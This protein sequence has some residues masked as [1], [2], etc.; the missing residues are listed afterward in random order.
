[1]IYIDKIKQIKRYKTI[2]LAV[3]KHPHVIDFVAQMF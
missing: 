1:M 3:E 2:L